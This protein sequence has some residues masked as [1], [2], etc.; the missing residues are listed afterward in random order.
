MAVLLSYL[1]KRDFYATVPAYSGQVT[2][3]KVPEANGHIKLVS[4]Q[5]SITTRRPVYW[6]PV[7]P[8][9]PVSMIFSSFFSAEEEKSMSSQSPQTVKIIF[10]LWN[11]SKVMSQISFTPP[12]LVNGNYFFF[13]IRP[14]KSHNMVTCFDWALSRHFVLFGAVRSL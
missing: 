2:F 6:I 14:K 13:I 5:W 12:Y 3:S 9:R 10:L 7:R 1:L 8:V 4:G 11:N